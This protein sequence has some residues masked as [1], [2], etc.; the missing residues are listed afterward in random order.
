ML[1]ADASYWISLFC[2]NEENYSRALELK[3]DLS[4]ETIY[5]NEHA[6]GEVF[7]FIARRHG[8]QVAFEKANAIISNSHIEVLQAGEDEW[9]EALELGRKYGF[10]FTDCLTAVQ[11]KKTGVRELVSFDSDFDKIPWVE[12]VS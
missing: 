9:R 4:H 3:D 1:F 10:S 2:E 12:R 7:T 6:F 8:G 11:M 5:V